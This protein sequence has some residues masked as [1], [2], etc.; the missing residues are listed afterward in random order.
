MKKNLLL[1]FCTICKE[2]KS[3]NYYYSYEKSINLIKIS[4]EEV[5]YIDTTKELL[6]LITKTNILGEADDCNVNGEEWTKTEAVRETDDSQMSYGFTEID[7]KTFVKKEGDQQ[8]VELFDL[9][10]ITKAVGE[11]NDYNNEVLL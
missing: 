8:D 10:T 7:T 4:G 1:E 3:P 9:D 2:Q 11:S 6:Q 5:P